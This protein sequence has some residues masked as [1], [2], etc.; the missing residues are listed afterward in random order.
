MVYCSETVKHS[1]FQGER[2]HDRKG[3]EAEAGEKGDCKTIGGFAVL[4]EQ[5]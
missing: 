1:I 5:S 4:G 3:E 2:T